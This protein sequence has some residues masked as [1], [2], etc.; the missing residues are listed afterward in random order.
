M[1]GIDIFS[2]AGG[3]SLGFE[4]AGFNISYAIEFNKDAAKTYESNRVDNGIH[5]DTR[6][7]ND[8]PPTSV[9]SKIPKAKK[10]IDIV[11]GGPPCQGFSTSN[12]KSR[13]MSN[14]NNR[15]IY[16]YCSYIKELKP[17]WF[18]LE[19]VAGLDS[20]N[21]GN[22]KNELI[23]QLAGFG[24]KVDSVI[25]NAANFGVPQ[26]RNRIFII[27]NNIGNK[28]SF[29]DDLANTTPEHYV[30][31]GDAIFDLPVIDN[32]NLVC[33]LPYN[34]HVLNQNNYQIHA[35]S[36]N[37]NNVV[38]NNLVTRHTE[39]AVKRF[40]LIGQG[41][42][43]IT[44]ASKHPEIV[45]N[46]KNIQNCHRWIYLRLRQDK[47]SVALNNFRKNM[48]IH[49]TQHRGLSIREAARLQS[50]PDNYVFHGPISHQQQQVANAVP[51]KLAEAI[52]SRILNEM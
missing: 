30:T 49:P 16:T 6:D 7:I 50:F 47:P 40:E 14:P 31:V 32:G 29:I 37:Q 23:N 19:N 45:T 1:L 18:V 44:L 28:M 9:W 33:T 8:I 34:P 41:E 2:G 43:L 27:G 39:L 46:Y 25:L 42:N 38:T 3:L 51:P 10:Q 26:N 17:K 21:K 24:Y 13:S 12:M 20:I 4:N 22:V 36:N 52:A 48:L 11:I 15:L 5:V 35:R